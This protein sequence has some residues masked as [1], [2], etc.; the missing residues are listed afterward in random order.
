MGDRKTTEVDYLVNETN[1]LAS[2]GLDMMR[3]S[4]LDEADTRA[5]KEIKKRTTVPIIA[6]IHFDYRFALMCIKAG[7]DKI[8]I[9]PGNIGGEAKLR[10]VIQACK[11]KHIPMRIGVN[12]GSLN[13]YRGKTT[14]KADDILLAL[15]ETLSI[16]K[17]EHF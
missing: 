13:K 4:I 2:I 1:T 15:D 16:F 6:D 7:V 8:R 12:S 5:I 9:N 14:S 11:E 10:T 17:E 3:F